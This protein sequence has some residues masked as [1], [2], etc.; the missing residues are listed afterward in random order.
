MINVDEAS[1]WPQNITLYSWCHKYKPDPIIKPSTRLNMIA[2][3]ILL[4]KYAVMLKIGSSKSEHIILFFEL[5]ESKLCDW[6]GKECIRSTI[7]VFDKASIHL[8][9]RTQSYLTYKKLSVLTLPP[10]TPEQNNVEQV[11]K[12]LKTD[13]S[14]CD[15][16][17]KRLEYIVTETIMAMK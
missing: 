11:F 1:V 5:L 3:M 13:L 17:K 7:I 2:T 12:R 6:F 9:D 8:S 15:F 14:S 4:H 10:Y 16:T